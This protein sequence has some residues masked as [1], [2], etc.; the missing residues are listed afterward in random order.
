MNYETVRRECIE[1]KLSTLRPSGDRTS[2]R[3]RAVAYLS[4]ASLYG[5]RAVNLTVLDAVLMVATL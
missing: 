3:P 5:F 2:S 1:K 4:I